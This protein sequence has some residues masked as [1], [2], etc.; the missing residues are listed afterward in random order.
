MLQ[1]YENISSKKN[2]SIAIV[3]N[4]YPYRATKQ[5]YIELFTTENSFELHGYEIP[6]RYIDY[7]IHVEGYFSGPSNQLDCFLLFSGNC[8]T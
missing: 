4:H 3:S 8:V 5:Y 7:V 6:C 1:K 2:T